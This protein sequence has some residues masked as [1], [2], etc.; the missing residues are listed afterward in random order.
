MSFS[1]SGGGHTVNKVSKYITIEVPGQQRYV[2][3]LYWYC[4]RQVFRDNRVQRVFGTY[5]VLNYKGE[6]IYRDDLCDR[7]DGVVAWRK[8]PRTYMRGFVKEV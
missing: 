7:T 1:A 8:I 3:D 4:D 6:R 2:M 5:Q